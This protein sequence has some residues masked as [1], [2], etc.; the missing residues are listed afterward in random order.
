MYDMTVNDR[1]FAEWLA[2]FES[3]AA[4]QDGDNLLGLNAIADR[5]GNAMIVAYVARNGSTGETV[6]LSPYFN[7]MASEP[8]GY[9]ED[10]PDRCELD[11][12]EANA[13]EWLDVMAGATNW[14]E[15]EWTE[16]TYPI[17]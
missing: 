9:D 12:I 16:I 15:W 6:R 11:D 3:S 14:H 7:Q 10:D 17:Y 1:A 8:Y 13:R 4:Y 2:E 5:M